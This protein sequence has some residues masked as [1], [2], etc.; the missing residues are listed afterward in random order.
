MNLR[1][2]QYKYLV[3]A[4]FIV[5]MFMD[6]MDLTIVNVA[7]PTFGQKFHTGE[8]TLEWV[9]TGYLLS[10]AIWIPA[11]GWIGDRFGTKKTFLFALF[12]FTLSSALCGLSWNI[13][14]L[15]IFRILQG[16]GGGMMTPVGVA[17]LFRAFPPQERAR[18]S[19]I[20]T[21]PT[22]IA[23]AIGP[24]IGG[25]LIDYVD[26]RWI[27]YV[28]VPMGIA[29]F[30]FCVLYL[31]EHTEE[32]AGGFDLAGFVLSGAGLALVLYALSRGPIDGWSSAPVLITGIGGL[33]CFAVLTVVELRVKEPMLDLRLFADRMFRNANIVYFASSASLIGVLF[34]LPLF[35][36]ELRGFSAIETGF[37]LFPSAVGVVV[38]A[39]LSGRLYPIVG[40]RRLLAVA[41]SLFALSSGLLLF[42][43]L[44]TNVWWIAAIMFV[45][46]I[47]MAFTFIPLQ[48]ATFS[49]ISN[50]R[51]GRASSLFN[52]NRQV[53]SSFGVAILATF[54]AERISS[55]MHAIGGGR[56]TQAAIDH[57][58]LLAYHDAFFAAVII[59][60]VGVAFAF[61]IHDEDAAA[62]MRAKP[63]A[64]ATPPREG[65]VAGH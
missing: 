37:I 4:G 48:A 2:V 28:N 32:L 30:I 54:L 57:A 10:L 46:G 22:V 6:L 27:F 16:V 58:Q 19:L 49:T 44:R 12:M 1:A 40:P 39:Q 38:F 35:L 24:I 56:P 63:G 20:L 55:H 47:A 51:T 52:T 41:L 42:V 62:T 23:P 7:L 34:L 50:E 65:V 11:S 60:V 8:S 59:G 15:I 26:W 36:Q 14:S 64:E 9:V 33:A 5:A 43:D 21:V 25:Y 18:A 3:A 53:G 31:Q 13:G 45:R 17:M 29:G 61:L